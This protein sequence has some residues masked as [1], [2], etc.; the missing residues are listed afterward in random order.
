MCGGICIYVHDFLLVKIMRKSSINLFNLVNA[1]AYNPIRHE[2][3]T[4]TQVVCWIR[5]SYSVPRYMQF[6][7]LNTS[8]FLY[9]ACGRRPVLFAQG[10]TRRYTGDVGCG[11]LSKP[12]KALS[13]R[14][15]YISCLKRRQTTTC[16]SEN[17]YDNDDCHPG[18]DGNET[19][20]PA[21]GVEGGG[22]RGFGS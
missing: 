21:H 1:N 18:C 11:L 22:G 19:Q 10:E 12:T 15:Q 7:F 9:P 6:T 17:I 16:S 8:I 14:E 2:A 4:S 3:A 5:I 13:P 20:T